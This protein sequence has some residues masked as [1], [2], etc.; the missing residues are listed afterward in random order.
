MTA[1]MD[2]AL[3]LVQDDLGRDVALATAQLLVVFLKRPGASHNSAPTS[4]HSLTATVDRRTAALDSRPPRYRSYHRGACERVNMS[5]RNFVRNFE[6]EAGTP[7][8]VFV[9]RRASMQRAAL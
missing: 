5:P 6:R 4:R 3:A 7:P 8:G 2:L 1:G 9:E